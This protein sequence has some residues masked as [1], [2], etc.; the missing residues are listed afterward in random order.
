MKKVLI[1]FG[2]IFI[3]TLLIP[4]ISMVDKSN[5]Q[6]EMVTIFNSTNGVVAD[7]L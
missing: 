1:I 2:I 4:L 6:N 7:E 3:T 5:N